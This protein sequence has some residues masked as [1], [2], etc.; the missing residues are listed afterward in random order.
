MLSPKTTF[1][2]ST[3]VLALL[4]ACGGG[5][6]GSASDTA[7][8][9]PAVTS[10]KPAGL[11]TA[12][13]AEQAYFL[14]SY[15][16]AGPLGSSTAKGYVRNTANGAGY[17]ERILYGREGAA[18]L[19]QN[20]FVVSERLVH[21]NGKSVALDAW[22]LGLSGAQS[23]PAGFYQQGAFRIQNIQEIDLSGKSFRD[24]FPAAALGGVDGFFPPGAKAYTASW[25]S[26]EDLYITGSVWSVVTGTAGASF[27]HN[28]F[29]SPTKAWCL[30]TSRALV[31]SGPTQAVSYPRSTTTSVAD[32]C[33]ADTSAPGTAHTVS[34]RLAGDI[35]YFDFSNSETQVTD[36][37]GAFFGSLGVSTHRFALLLQDF[38]GGRVS[39]TSNVF[40]YPEGS[41]GTN[42]AISGMRMNKTALNAM[43]LASAL[44]PAP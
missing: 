8:P 5:G 10:P 14:D 22:Q 35:W 39:A 36:F 37:V 25:Q 3:L 28:N 13:S 12:N 4:A 19:A 34:S 40:F 26:Q 20:T 43:L 9:A 23:T 42:A 38:G 29:S 44:P 21:H 31:F 32:G 24:Y 33:V 30:G 18:Y 1:A 16:F 41:Q 6:G 2:I 15:E 17:P 7:S 11:V 27:F